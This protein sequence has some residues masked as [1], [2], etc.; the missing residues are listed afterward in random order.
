MYGGERRGKDE[1]KE[2]KGRGGLFSLFVTWRFGMDFGAEG[3][4]CVDFWVCMCG[5]FGGL[6]GQVCLY[7]YVWL[8][9]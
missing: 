1:A 6:S 8:V 7:F 4:R 5:G 3:G 9:N 2:G